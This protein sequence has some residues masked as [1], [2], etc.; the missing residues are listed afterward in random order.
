MNDDTRE[1]TP[2]HDIIIELRTEVKGMRADLKGFSD[3]TKERLIRVE[4]NK[5]DSRPSPTSLLMTKPVTSTRNGASDSSNA[6]AGP[7][8]VLSD[9]SSSPSS[10]T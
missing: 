5:L 2:D 10:S 4:E 6:G 9:S 1:H 7:R 3:D 8:G